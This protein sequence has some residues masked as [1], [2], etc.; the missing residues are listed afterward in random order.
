MK[1]TILMLFAVLL[2]NTPLFANDYA[3]IRF[4]VDPN[5]APFAYKDNKGTLTGFEVDIDNFGEDL[6]G[7]QVIPY[8][9][10]KHNQASHWAHHRFYSR[11]RRWRIQ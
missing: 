7:R 3:V 5:Y 9:R 4:G 2:L 8:L 6:P 10:E 11:Q 1:K